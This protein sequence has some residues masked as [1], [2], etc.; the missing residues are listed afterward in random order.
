MLRLDHGSPIDPVTSLHGF[1]VSFTTS[2]ESAWPSG[3]I[4]TMALIDFHQ[5]ALLYRLTRGDAGILSNR[6]HPPP[7]P[8]ATPSGS[9]PPPNELDNP[10]SSVFPPTQSA[11]KYLGHKP[12]ATRFVRDQTPLSDGTSIAPKLRP[13]ADQARKYSSEK[14]EQ[15]I[16]QDFERHRVFV[17]I[18]VFMENVLHVPNDWR[19]KWGGEI[20]K[21]KHDST[22][23]AALMSY[24]D[25]C[26][27]SGALERDFYQPL[28]KTTNAILDFSQLS[29]QGCIKPRTPQR[30]VVNDPKKISCGVMNDLSPDIVAVHQDFL[31]HMGDEEGPGKKPSMTWAHPLQML[32]VKPWD[33]ALVDGSCMPRLGVNGERVDTFWD[34]APRLTGN[35]TGSARKPRACSHAVAVHEEEVK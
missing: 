23:V 1:I 11:P 26:N 24:T 7:M 25:Q 35:R 6:S 18:D 14:Y 34:D 28:V 27:T 16:V 22:F 10:G 13:D 8:A 12:D 20:T 9:H 21:I 19:K 33:N 32:E 4:R 2:T 15:Y 17:D 29:S 3:I 30:Y 31:P 5:L